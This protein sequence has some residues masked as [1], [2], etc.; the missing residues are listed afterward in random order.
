MLIRTVRA[1]SESPLEAADV[2]SDVIMRQARP[3]EDHVV[4][5][6]DMNR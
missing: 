3:F 1:G 5:H 2:P 4:S 6:G